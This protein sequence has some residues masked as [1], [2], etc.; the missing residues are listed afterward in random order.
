MQAAP[1]S[2]TL[3]VKFTPVD[4]ALGTRVKARTT[5]FQKDAHLGKVGLA[6]SGNSGLVLSDN[7][8]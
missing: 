5:V 2:Y 1:F 7:M 6:R 4:G 3:R 8:L